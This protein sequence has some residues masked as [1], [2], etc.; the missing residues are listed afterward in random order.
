[1]LL[2]IGISFW[3]LSV[4]E[5]V[6]DYDNARHLWFSFEF[7][8]QIRRGDLTGPFE[9]F[10]AYPPLTHL[11]GAIGAFI[12]G[13]N[14]I[15]PVMSQ[16]LVFLPLLALGCYRTGTFFDGPRAGLLAVLF[17]LGTPMLISQF[18]VFMLD[19][20]TAALVAVS[21]WLL[22]ETDRFTNRNFSLAAGVVVGLGMLI[23]STFVLFVIGLV[24]VL[25]L[26]GGWRNWRNLVLFGAAAAILGLPWHIAHF[27]DQADLLGGA[28]SGDTPRW[29]GSVHYPARWTLDDFTWYGW[30]LINLQ[31]YV[32]LTIVLLVGAVTA[33]TRWLRTRRSDDYAPELLAGALFGYLSITWISLNDPRYTLPALVYAAVL[34]TAWIARGSPLVRTA[35]TAAVVGLFVL[36]TATVSFG[37]GSPVRIDLP[38]S[39]DKHPVERA[40]SGEVTLIGEG[41]VEGAPDRD[42]HLLE[43]LKR[44]RGD[45]ADSVY[46]AGPRF[47]FYNIDGLALLSHMARLPY[48]NG[49]YSQPYLL[50]RRRKSR[51][52]DPQPCT[53]LV[54]G[55]AIYAQLVQPEDSFTA[56]KDFGSYC[57]LD[58]G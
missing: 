55:S 45:G 8:D 16:N 42:S 18:H 52:G 9:S 39:S 34:G 27:A 57:P 29:F 36:N 33:L 38:N 24:A 58:R 14:V 51:P 19:A 47:V 20:P 30:D 35:G 50:I 23:K 7:H 49:D 13:K 44:A 37:L 41:Y 48:T 5:R 28:A 56:P 32:P 4:D 25:A 3:W 6:P 11:I 2:F 31:A 43:L 53:R 40:L 54:D 46:F 12:G 22:L 26:R 15:A 10:N 21:V 17:A 1:M